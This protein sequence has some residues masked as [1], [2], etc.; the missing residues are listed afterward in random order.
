MSDP[1]VFP[2]PAEFSS[3][4]NV[5]NLEEYRALYERAKANPAS[6]WG[7]LAGL[8][9]GQAGDGEHVPGGHGDLL[10]AEVGREAGAV[11]VAASHGVTE[12]YQTAL[13]NWQ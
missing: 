11:V 10:P 2:P 12:R 9:P 13:H 4:A 8:G 3:R 6:F 5:S 1:H 7:D